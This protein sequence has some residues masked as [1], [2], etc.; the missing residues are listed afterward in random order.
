MNFKPDPDTVLTH[1]F[2]LLAS[3]GVD[4]HDENFRDTPR[5]FSAY[6]LEHFTTEEHWNEHLEKHSK[7]IFPSTYRGMI[8]QKVAAIGMCPHHLL[9]VLYSGSVAYLPWKTTIGL[10]KL[11]R[12]TSLCLAQPILQET[13][14]VL[15]AET[16]QKALDTESVGVI[17]HG[18]HTCMSI[19]GVGYRD[20]VTTTSE[21]RGEFFTDPTARS[22]FMTLKQPCGD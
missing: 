7:A 2:N 20:A 9:P 6:L 22:E 12:I 4:L 11:A 3:L 5:R 14:T 8:I 19:R 1:V 16:L 17:L 21:L 15:V 13:G 10:S 18:H